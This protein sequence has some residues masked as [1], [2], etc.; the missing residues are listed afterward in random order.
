M[1]GGWKGISQFRRCGGEL[2]GISI[3][4]GIRV[5]GWE[6]LVTENPACPIQG[7]AFLRGE[8]VDSKL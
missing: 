3:F 5:G 7:I 1:W 4:G 2:G 8:A 6:L